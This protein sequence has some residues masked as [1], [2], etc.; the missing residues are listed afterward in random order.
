MIKLQDLVILTQIIPLTKF[1]E[2][3]NIP[4]HNLYHRIVYLGKNKKFKELTTAES[5]RITELLS[6]VGLTYSNEKYYQVEFENEY[7]KSKN[8]DDLLSNESENG[9]FKLTN[10]QVELLHIKTKLNINEF[11]IKND[12]DRIKELINK[13]VKLPEENII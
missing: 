6:S 4:I 11:L 5:I 13:G 9:V 12:F 1:A 3:L 7:A 8:N 2:A 10:E